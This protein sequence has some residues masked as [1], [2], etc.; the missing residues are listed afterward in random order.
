[1]LCFGWMAKTD[2]EGCSSL[3]LNQAL[4]QRACSQKVMYYIWDSFKCTGHLK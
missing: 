4:S 3:H 1:M 2:V